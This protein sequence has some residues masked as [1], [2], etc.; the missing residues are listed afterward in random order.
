M[1]RKKKK[2]YNIILSV[3]IL[4]LVISNV[5]IYNINN[6]KKIHLKKLEIALKEKEEMTN[7][8]NKHKQD[9]ETIKQLKQEILGQQT[10]L[11]E[12]RKQIDSFTKT[13]IENEKKL[14]KLE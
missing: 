12:F 3:I 7:F 5:Y 2:K 4:M 14:E 9:L 6:N 10:K 1:S 13:L 8:L 11:E